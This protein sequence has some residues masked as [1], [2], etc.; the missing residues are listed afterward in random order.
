MRTLSKSDFKLARSCIT[1]LY[2]KELGYPQNSDDNP[3]LAMLAE[4][5]Y[6]VEQLARLLYPTGITLEYARDV[7]ADWAQTRELL[8]RDIVTLFEATL[9]AGR[10]QARVDIL[11]KR[12]NRLDLIE[13]KSK[14]MDGDDIDE[15]PEGP[16]RAKV[17]R[18]G[19][20]QIRK[21]WMPYLEDVAYQT[22]VLRELYPDM[23]VRPHLLVVDKSKTTSV[24]GLPG[25]FTVRRD[26]EEDGRRKDLD[27]RFTGD[28]ES[29]DPGEFLKLVEVSSEV[30]ELMPSIEADTA[31]FLELYTDD[32]V[33]RAKQELTWECRACEFRMKGKHELDGL[34]ECWGELATPQPHIFDLYYLG[35]VK[36]D[37][38]RLAD[39]LILNGKTSLYDVPVEFLTSGR[40]ARQLVQIEHSRA[41]TKWLHD[42]LKEE[43]GAL[44][45]PLHF[46]DFETSLLAIPYHKGMRPY[47]KVAFQWSCH[48]ITGPGATPIHKEWLNADATWPNEA[49]IRSLREAVGDEGRILTWS[50]YERTVLNDILGQLTRYGAGDPD[51]FD[52]LQRVLGPTPEESRIFDLNDLCLRAYFHPGMGGR[53]SIKVVLDALW[54]DDPAMRARY[55]EWGGGAGDPLVGPYEAL[56]PVIVAGTELNVQEGTGAMRAYQAIMYGAEKHDPVTVSV[57]RDLLRRYCKLDTMAMV[58]IWDHWRRESGLDTALIGS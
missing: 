38:E 48:T 39:Q 58:L 47:E 49:F 34:A 44:G 54:K 24:E 25:F 20:Y 35:A 11:V 55:E 50:G 7:E 5:G 19:A 16:F 2:Y 30:D 46:I 45:W 8:T 15:G 51:L 56:P 41:K 29:V 6:M 52:W 9:L 23:E 4:G 22:L 10:K 26:I 14:S 37:K 1:K 12:G 17:R 27:V 40:S 43:L 53:T 21:P 31:R 28:P 32:G 13:V 57:L 18:N 42:C 36:V 33:L 3:Y